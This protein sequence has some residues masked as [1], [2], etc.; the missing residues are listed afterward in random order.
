MDSKLYTVKI[1]LWV[2]ASIVLIALLFDVWTLS[3][4][5]GGPAVG[6]LLFNLFNMGTCVFVLVSIWVTRWVQLEA[7][8]LTPDETPT[9]DPENQMKY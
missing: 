2:N 3:Q 9:I 5:G 7:Y 8:L 6:S 4:T 1:V